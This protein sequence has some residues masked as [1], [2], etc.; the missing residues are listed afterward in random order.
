[1]LQC[2]DKR[3]ILSFQR[4]IGLIKKRSLFPNTDES[5]I[6]IYNSCEADTLPT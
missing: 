1:M 6:A 4:L 2:S 5:A 3:L